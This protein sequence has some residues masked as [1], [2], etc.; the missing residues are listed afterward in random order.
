MKNQENTFDSLGK[1]IVSIMFRSALSLR[2]SNIGK[3]ESWILQRIE[4]NLRSKTI[5]S[6]VNDQVVVKVIYAA[7]YAIGAIDQSE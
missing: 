4:H 1:R 6:A 7:N 3:V 5:L 2:V